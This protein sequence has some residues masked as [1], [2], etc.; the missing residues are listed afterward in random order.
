MAKLTGEEI[1]AIIKAGHESATASISIGSLVIKYKGAE[2]E[3]PA[4][5]QVFITSDKPTESP[6]EA[7]TDSF[8]D[9]QLSILN[10]EEYEQQVILGDLNGEKA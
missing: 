5:S 8:D 4:T 6:P 9:Y 3:I 10:P 1:V 7:R 2:P